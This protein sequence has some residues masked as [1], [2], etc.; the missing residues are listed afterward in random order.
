M[1]YGELGRILIDICVKLRVIHFWNKL[2]SN[3]NKLSFI[4]YKTMFNL[5]IIDN[6]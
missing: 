5:S 6:V 1:T 3:Q 4:L 2:I